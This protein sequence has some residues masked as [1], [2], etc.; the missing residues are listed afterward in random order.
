MGGK[1]TF[2]AKSRTRG[3][4]ASAAATC[5]ENCA[6]R[7][8]FGV[9]RRFSVLYDYFRVRR[10]APNVPGANGTSTRSAF[11]SQVMVE[12]ETASETDE[13]SQTTNARP[14]FSC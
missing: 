4:T 11:D 7:A 12:L 14:A 10:Y 1:P 13:A 9:L 8:V 6:G 5:S 2:Q 3:G